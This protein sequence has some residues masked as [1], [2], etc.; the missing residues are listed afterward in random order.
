MNLCLEPCSVFM[1]PFSVRSKPCSVRSEPCN[2]HITTCNGFL[3]ISDD[4]ILPSER[5]IILAVD[6]HRS[7]GMGTVGRDAC[8]N[9][10]FVHSPVA[11]VTGDVATAQ[12]EGHVCCDLAAEN[13]QGVRRVPVTI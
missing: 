8:Q 3:D 9:L 12:V 5:D 10:H 13:S 11:S 7:S 4:G 1:E 2:V 6:A